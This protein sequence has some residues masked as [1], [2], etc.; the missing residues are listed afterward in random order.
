[1]PRLRPAGRVISGYAGPGVTDNMRPSTGERAGSDHAGGA[2][3]L[4][5]VNFQLLM[6]LDMLIRESHVTHAAERL[7]ITQPTMSS[8]LSKLRELFH[9]P[10]LVKTTHGMVPTARGLELAERARRIIELLEG[11]DTV[12]SFDPGTCSSQFRLFTTEA[13]ALAL[14]PPLGA[15]VRKLAPNLR[16]VVSTI[17][18]RHTQDYLRD[19]DCDLAVNYLRRP[20]PDLRYVPLF[21]QPVT[22][23]VSPSHPDIQ[24]SMNLE[25]FLAYPHVLW[26]TGLAPQRFIEL[27]VDD[28][29]GR[30]RRTRPNALR[31]PNLLMVPSVVAATDMIGVVPAR[32]AEQGR[33]DLGLQVLVPPLRLERPEVRMFW[34]ERTHRDPLHAWMRALVRELAVAT[35]V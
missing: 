15:R 9:D 25:Q 6:Q 2:M 33:R 4:R 5:R 31:V 35:S 23:L 26:G 27:M 14:L 28:A 19:G 17:D 1:M 12:V 21:S 30:R 7:G 20:A 8:S 13:I 29:L 11:Q 34:H 16:L 24:G 3:D 32:I 10:L 18:V 22:C